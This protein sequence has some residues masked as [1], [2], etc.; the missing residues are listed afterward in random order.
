MEHVQ[1]TEDLQGCTDERHMRCEGSHDMPWHVVLAGIA[2]YGAYN[3]RYGGNLSAACRLL[4][5]LV[6]RLTMRT[7]TTRQIRSFDERR[8]RDPRSLR[9]LRIGALCR[10]STPGC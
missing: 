4:L 5:F 9:L 3:G 1:S 2:A 10:A 6:L 8:S 7:P